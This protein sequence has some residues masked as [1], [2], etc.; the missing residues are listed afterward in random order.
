MPKPLTKQ[1]RL[2]ALAINLLQLCC[3]TLIIA[4]LL[5]LSGCHKTEVQ[6]GGPVEI[7]LWHPWG[8]D[9]AKGLQRIVDLYHHSQNRVRVRLVFTPTDLS[10]NQK[11]FTAVA[12]NK[13]PD[14]SFVDG[15]QV[16]QWAEWGALLPLDKYIQ[17]AGI[18][19]TDYYDP[20]WKQ[21]QYQGQVWAMT[22]CADP[23]FA[24]CWNKELFRKAG[25]NPDQPP[26]TIEDIDAMAQKLTQDKNGRL[27]SL[28]IIPWS[29]YGS[30][31]SVFTWGWAF[32]GKFYDEKNGRITANNPRVVKAVEWMASYAKKLG[33]TR[34]NSATSGWGSGASD[35]FITGNLAMRC[36]HISTLKDLTRYGPNLDYGIAPIPGTPDG[37]IGSSW[38]G[39]WLLAL[40]R[41]CA[42]PDAAWDFVHW[43]CATPEGTAAIAR[44]VGLLPGYRRSPAIAQVKHDPRLGMFVKILEDSKHQ[45]PVMPVQ[46]FF[47]GALDRAVERAIYAKQTPQEA[48]DQATA[49][50]QRELDLVSGKKVQ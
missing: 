34:V 44:E 31:N 1:T 22:Y 16:A 28:G 26:R 41:G 45:R 36:V 35:P 8:S 20:C 23:N 13:P 21:A 48:M 40:P 7:T 42:H 27:L 3:G 39:G 17:Q 37:E 9:Q 50:T 32:G 6:T 29:Q 38:V 14:A 2:L 33:I 18:K 47:M 43:A 46:A 10:T 15:T 4:I 11:F 30:A 25:L 12:A 19:P 5:I 49:E 24:F